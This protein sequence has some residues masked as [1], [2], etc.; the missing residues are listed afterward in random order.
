MY[1]NMY[2]DV[3]NCDPTP[4]TRGSTADDQV[5]A[6]ICGHAQVL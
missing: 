1:V 6:G 4:R 3:V 5:S 2:K